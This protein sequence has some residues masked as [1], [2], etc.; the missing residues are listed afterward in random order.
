MP[1]PKRVISTVNS[2]DAQLIVLT[3]ARQVADVA[4]RLVD[5]GIR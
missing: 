3:G 2:L 5:A 1:G 4:S